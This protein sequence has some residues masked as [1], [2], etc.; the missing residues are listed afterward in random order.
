MTFLISDALIIEDDKVASVVLEIV[1][2]RIG[3][4]REKLSWSY[5]KF[6]VGGGIEEIKLRSYF[7]TEEKRW[8]VSELFAEFGMHQQQ[9]IF[10]NVRN[11]QS[12]SSLD[13]GYIVSFVIRDQLAANLVRDR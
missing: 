7:E 3:L 5:N 13:V 4:Q 6:A 8:T 1:D 10:A 12:M 9:V 11:D 2:I